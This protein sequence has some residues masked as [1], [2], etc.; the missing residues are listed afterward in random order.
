M[1]PAGWRG[2]A[3]E[4]A[5]EGQ[6]DTTFILDGSPLFS[7]IGDADHDGKTDLVLQQPSTYVRVFESPDS[8]SFPTKEVWV[9]K[10]QY[11]AGFASATFTDLDQDS[12]TE[13]VALDYP[14][15]QVRVYE[16]VADDSYALKTC[17]PGRGCDICELDDLDRDG[18]P[19]LAITYIGG[20]EVRFYEAVADDSILCVAEDTSLRPY[21]YGRGMAYA[22]D[23]D[24]DGLSEMIA[25][26]QDGDDQM[27]IGVY[28][29]PANNTFNLV[30]SYTCPCGQASGGNAA[31]GDIDGDS[32][33]EFAVTDGIHVRLFRCTGN[34]HYE[35]IWQ[36]PDQSETPVA[37]C[38]LNSDGK[39][40]LLYCHVGW[41]IIREYV[42]LGV[43][44]LTRRRL[45]QVGVVPTIVAQR[46]G[47]RVSG[48]GIGARM[49]VVDAAGRVVA[50]PAGT[51][52]EAVWRTDKARPGAYFIR[53]SSGRQ[54][55][56]RKVLVVD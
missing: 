1:R 38:D 10:I 45:E 4:W 30:W 7:D 56:T 6:F 20:I 12:F 43:E 46:E 33:L 27:I 13:I 35:Q 17:I 11:N 22:P 41:T 55:I 2:Y 49:E 36:S 47:V 16:N 53:V 51:G 3:A 31:V 29:A 48:S 40:E 24:R 19:E 23:M 25:A 18:K 44:E 52:E 26:A 54:S 15:S 5:G 21:P 42:S 9:D 39:D 50:Q 14:A 8:W 37:L 32:A 28:E 34:D